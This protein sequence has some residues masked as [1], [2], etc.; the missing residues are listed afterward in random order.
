LK[1]S[2]L[3]EQ[4][5]KPNAIYTWD[6]TM[7]FGV[8][9]AIFEKGLNIPQDLELVGHNDIEKAKYFNP[10]LTTVKERM[11]EVGEKA[12]NLLIQKIESKQKWN[13]PHKIILQPELIIRKTTS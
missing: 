1:A 11:L 8:I 3:L 9:R 13:K 2:N 12:T 6:D 5:D 4:V 7:A 10:P